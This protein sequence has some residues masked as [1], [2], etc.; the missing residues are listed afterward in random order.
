MP[1]S[2]ATASRRNFCVS[3]ECL[4][5]LQSDVM[6]QNVAMCSVEWGSWCGGFGHFVESKLSEEE[7]F[8]SEEEPT[9][10]HHDGDLGG[11]IA[12]VATDFLDFWPRRA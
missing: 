5:F 11:A 1:W 4:Y 8:D 3:R 2:D 7:R 9:T 10:I 6:T 12:V